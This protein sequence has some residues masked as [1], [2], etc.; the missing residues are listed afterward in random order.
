M[1]SSTASSIHSHLNSLKDHYE[2]ILAASESK[3]REA[4]EQLI[5]IDALLENTPQPDGVQKKAPSSRQRSS[6]PAPVAKTTR[7]VTKGTKRKASK[8]GRTMA[9]T[10]LAAFEGMS[11]IDAVAKIFQDNHGKILHLDDIIEELLGELSLAELEAER[12][13]MKNV[14]GRGVKRGLWTK[15]QNVPLSYILESPYPD[16]AISSATSARPREINPLTRLEVK[17]PDPQ[18]G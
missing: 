11:K 17:L 18:Q 1:P 10:P 13:R 15:V 6:K 8:P 16:P 9:L 2:A 4:K 12:I 7:R 3:V 5:H 14:M